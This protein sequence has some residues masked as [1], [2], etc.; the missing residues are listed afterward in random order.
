M[1]TF[2]NANFAAGIQ[3]FYRSESALGRP[4][5]YVEKMAAGNPPVVKDGLLQLPDGPGLGLDLNMDFIK[6]ILVPGEPFWS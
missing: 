2:A 6:S 1:L 3:N 5:H 4:T